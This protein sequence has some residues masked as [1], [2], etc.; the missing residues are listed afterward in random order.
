MKYT[1]VW[2]L[3]MYKL[4]VIRIKDLDFK[5]KIINDIITIRLLSK[6]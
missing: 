2:D 1:I 4:L 6:V 5:Y 3:K